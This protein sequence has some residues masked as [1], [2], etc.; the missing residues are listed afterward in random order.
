MLQ[1]LIQGQM[2]IINLMVVLQRKKQNLI[3]QVL[4]HGVMI[5][6][7][8]RKSGNKIN[9]LQCIFFS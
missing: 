4:V 2:K 8:R 1:E 6:K 7:Y 5:L 9:T 3:C